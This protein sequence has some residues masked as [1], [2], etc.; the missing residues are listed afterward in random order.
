[1]SKY[2][3]IGDKVVNEQFPDLPSREV[4]KVS[5]TADLIKISNPDHSFESNVGLKTFEKEYKKVN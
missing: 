4:V 1:M 5:T 3:N 2:P